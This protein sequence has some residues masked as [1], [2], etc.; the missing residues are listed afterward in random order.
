MDE[1]I[2]HRHG[3]DIKDAFRRFHIPRRAVVD[4]SVNTN[5]L[6]HP[7]EALKAWKNTKRLVEAY[8]SADGRKVVEFYS[9]R[10]SVPEE[11]VVAGCGSMEFIYLLPQL[12]RP[13]RVCVVMPTFYNYSHALT[14]CGSTIRPL[15]LKPSSRFEVSSVEFFSSL[16]GTDMLWLCRPNNPTG[17]LIPREI[18]LELLKRFPHT[19]VVVDETFIQFA[20]GF[21]EE[22]LIQDIQRYGNLVILHSLTKFYA[23]AGLRVGA[24]IAPPEL[25]E[26]VRRCKPPWTVN[27]PAELAV[28][29][30]LACQ[31]YE[32]KTRILIKEE[33]KRLERAIREL[34]GVELFST[35]ANFFLARWH[36]TEELDHLVR[37]LLLRGIYIRDCR[38]FPSLE[39]GYFR[40]AIKMPHENDALLKALGEITT[41][42]R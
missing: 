13:A 33:R 27:T 31:N 14:L 34:P 2:Y 39:A 11:C 4:F 42:W 37:E 28:E 21:P 18:V 23:L 25:A 17:T 3:G 7:P 19:T 12:L 26:R 22:S 9:K 5:P 6:G 15:W 41:Q 38:N 40:F 24:L 35:R 29:G 30:L 20:E 8:P 10:F 36:L 1:G 32:E 16:R